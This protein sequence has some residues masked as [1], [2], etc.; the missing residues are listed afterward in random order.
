M[1]HFLHR[2]L[3]S[4]ILIG[5]PAMAATAQEKPRSPKAAAARA[6][7]EQ[8][9]TPTS[10]TE[11]MLYWIREDGKF[12]Y[13]DN[14]GKVVIPVQYENTFGFR[15]GLAG[16]RING[17]HGYIDRTGRLVIPAIFDSTYA[18]REG[19]AW[20]KQDGKYGYIDKT[21]KMVIPPQ[22]DDAEDFS[23]GLAAV[24]VGNLYGYIDRTGKM[25]IPPPSFPTPTASWAGWRRS[26]W[27]S[28]RPTLTA[29]GACSGFRRTVP[30]K[31]PGKAT[32]AESRT[33]TDPAS[34]TGSAP[35]S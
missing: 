13:I 16:V 30:K 20:V 25:V 18:F 17:K 8:K 23:E 29:P 28:G 31:A 10:S 21:G 3:T 33:S 32:K 1:H 7:S 24:K 14:T 9:T 6:A 27:T 15:E 4:V 5:L 22:F 26:W 11:D 35:C 19:L 2:V 12:G 34:P